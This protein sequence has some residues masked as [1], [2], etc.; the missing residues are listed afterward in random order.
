MSQSSSSR[1]SSLSSYYSKSP[2]GFR[3]NSGAKHDP[4]REP[5]FE[6]R[7]IHTSVLLG[8]TEERASNIWGRY[9]S[10]PEDMGAD[11]VNFARWAIEEPAIMLE[12]FEDVRYTATCKYWLLDAIN[13]VYEHLEQ[14]NE[15]Q[16]SNSSRRLA[17]TPILSQ[18]KGRKDH[19]HMQTFEPIEEET[20]MALQEERPDMHS[21]IL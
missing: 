6:L 17:K 11:F 13:N 4:N 10:Q 20:S 3:V 12:D 14:L 5:P 8:F 15:N 2:G 1:K 7:S 19:P 18:P 21:D 16:E 9:N